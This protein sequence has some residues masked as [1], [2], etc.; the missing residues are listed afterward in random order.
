MSDVDDEAPKSGRPS[1]YKPEYAETARKLC[2][3]GATTSELADFFEVSVSTV[4][5]WLI[6][7]PEFSESVK[8]GKEVADDRVEESLYRR[9]CGYEHDETDIRVVANEL[10]MTPIRK[11]YP[12]DSTAM[13]F[14]LKNRRSEAWRDKTQQE[15]TGA[16]GGPI[17]YEELP[18]EQL[19]AK[20]KAL[21]AIHP[22]LKG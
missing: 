18:T 15:H 13:I 2:K 11:H 22:E 3:L 17:Q 19:L 16:N 14:W 12:P 6:T 20:L 8:K 21:Q 9:A 7:H 5:L 1:L 4:S 10:V